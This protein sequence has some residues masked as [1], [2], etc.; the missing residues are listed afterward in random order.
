MELWFALTLLAI[1]LVAILYSSVGHGG[2][3]GYLAVLSLSSF[4][5]ND[6]AWLK[7]HAWTLNL[8]VASI[9]FYH[10]WR[11]GHHIP[12]LTFPFIVASIPF[13]LVGGYLSISGGIYDLLLSIA[14]IWAAYRL[15]IVNNMEEKRENIDVDMKVALPVGGSIGFFSGVIGVGG[16]IFLSPILLLKG[17]A[18]PKSAAA[19]AALFIWVNSA[20]GL[21]GAALSGQIILEFEVLIWFVGVVVVGG[22]IGSHYGAFFASQTKIRKILIVVL[23]FAAAKRI[24]GLF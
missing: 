24:I 10:Y 18:T 16:G 5:G 2:A 6:S 9:A 11:S 14:L 21:T 1:G 20:A 4:A 15:L 17:W 8:V 3:S 22:F 23:F 13:A 7:Q 12:K 19:T